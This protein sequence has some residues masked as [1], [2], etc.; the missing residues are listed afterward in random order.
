MKPAR[1]ACI[2]VL[3]AASAYASEAG[4]TP[5]P[6]IQRV[7]PEQ[8]QAHLRTLQNVVADC[9]RDTTMRSCLASRVGADD[10]V[11]TAH[12]LRHVGFAWLRNVLDSAAALN[13][14]KDTEKMRSAASRMLVEAG[15]RLQ[16]EQR[17]G[18]G[19]GTGNGQP[20]DLRNVPD[21]S[22]AQRTLATIL[23][24]SDF[25]HVVQP[26]LLAQV[27]NGILQWLDRR[28]AGAAN[29]SRRAHWIT[30]LFLGAVVL[31][32]CT[33][34][35]WWFVVQSKRQG[36]GRLSPSREWQ[37]GSPATHDWRSWRDEAEGL[38]QAGRWREAVHGL[39]WAAIACLEARGLW[40][41]DRTRTPREY[42]AIL[43]SGN[44]SRSDLATLTH[45]FE[46]IWYGHRPAGRREYEQARTLLE[47]LASR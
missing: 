20:G 36:M 13:G 6:P 27:L 22:S 25:K 39:Y 5:V 29:Y 40:S 32:A 42:L 43:E 30:R 21:R 28:L 44:K 41:E 26:N 10:D 1:L 46:C 24:G 35:V 19:Q 8:Y 14:A 37:P 15:D 2:A 45:S 4:L 11:V 12:G 47:R 16:E 34:L 17:L 38:S 3:A 18:P 9:A 33:T 23:A 7:T 31:G